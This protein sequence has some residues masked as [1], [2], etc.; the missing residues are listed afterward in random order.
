M[1]NQKGVTAISMMVLIVIII[2]LAS[3]SI[4][5]S[6][7]VVVEGNIT[8]TYSEISIIRDAALNLSLDE[9]YRNDGII[10]STKIQN[11]EY[12]NSRVGGNLSEGKTYYYLPFEGENDVLV[13]SLN[14][15]LDVRSVENSYII[16]IEDVGKVEVYLV[17]GI[18]ID[19]TSYYSYD[20][21]KAVYSDMDR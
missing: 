14:E 15:K 13:Q 1:K 7:D 10:A 20:D 4:L 11:I 6:R 18:R 16:S 19:N 5:S 8:A 17:D 3:F 12:Y 21:I 2:L 9:S